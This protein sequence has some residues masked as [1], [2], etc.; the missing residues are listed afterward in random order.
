[1]KPVAVVAAWIAAC[2]AGCAAAPVGPPVGAL[3]AAAREAP[4]RY[5][6]VTVRNEGAPVSMRAAGTPRGYD[7]VATYSVGREA[8]ALARGIATDYDLVEAAAWP[9]QLL[10]VHC[11]VYSLPAGVE[12]SALLQRL[13]A[14]RR[15]ESAQPLARFATQTDAYNDPYARLQQS[16]AQMAVP[17]AQQWS[18]G[19]G[20]RLAIIDTGVD[21]QHPD[22]HGRVA[23]EHNF[24]DA[25][26]NGF[27]TDRHGTAVAGV[28]TAV[29]NNRIGIAGIAPE[30]TL[31]A[32]K[33][34][35]HSARAPGAADCNTFTLAQALAAAIDARVDVVNLSL[36]GPS[37]PLLARLLRRG[38]QRGIVFVGAAPPEGAHAGFPGDVPGV[39]T[40]DAPHRRR[41]TPAALVA[42]GYDVLTLVP[43][44]HYDFASGSS[45]AAAQA[46]GVV[47]LMLATDR[48]LDATQV[49]RLLEQTSHPVRG[50]AETFTSIDACAALVALQRHGHCAT[51]TAAVIENL[52]HE[53]VRAER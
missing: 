14:D 51:T 43:G 21:T 38:Q 47:A 26:A 2:V 50:P 1:M 29:A 40:V 36:A 11:V 9:I 32:Y 10:Q 13:A 42:P 12:R 17:E 37:D 23:S 45:L 44:A 28:I 52:E 22:L 15:V 8:Q 6:V 19:A 46:S 5:V 49:L 53:A 4:E 7:T 35:W 20:V 16:L 27:R 48:R 3:P 33:A 18:R 41:G 24:V 34:C 25:D 39:I 30:V 31:L